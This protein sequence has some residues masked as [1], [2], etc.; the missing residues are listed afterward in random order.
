MHILEVDTHDREE[1]LDITPA[2]R[3]MLRENA[4][5]DGALLLYCPHTTGAVTV[6]E[7]ADP[8]V[9]RDILVNMD[10][11]VPRN[12]DYRHAEGNSDAHIK[13]SLFGCDQLVIVEDGDIRLGTWQKIYFCEFDGPRS[14]KLWVQWLG[15]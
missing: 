11:L 8:D 12:G 4:W 10:K 2:V 5:T 6:N 1:L 13:S 15:V 7:G 14:R 9:V 3:R